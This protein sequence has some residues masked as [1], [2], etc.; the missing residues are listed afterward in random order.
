MK[1]R[2]PGKLVLSGAYSVL[3]G[4]PAVVAAVDRYVLVDASQPAALL[5]REVG[6]AIDEGF[7]SQAPSFDASQ[8][9]QS[10]ASGASRKLGLGS[11]AAILSASLAAGRTAGPGLAEKVFPDALRCH[12]KA[13]EGGSGVDV[14]AACFGGVILCRMTGTGGNLD[15]RP[16]ALPKGLCI[17]TWSCPTSVSTREMLAK[18]GRFELAQASQYQ[19]WMNRAKAAAEDVAHGNLC[20]RDWMLAVAEQADALGELGR[21]AGAPIVTTRVAELNRLAGAD[22]A[23]FVPSGAGGGDVALH[24]GLVPSTEAFRA[25]AAEA[26]MRHLELTLGAPGLALEDEA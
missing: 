5:T 3:L 14:A 17:E 4:A 21:G 22:E 10:L 8:L 2:A 25:A 1:A 20:A 12:R 18:I 11:S 13:Q 7:L 23:F 16:Y 6:V 15:V 24:L 19:R 9:R 26:G